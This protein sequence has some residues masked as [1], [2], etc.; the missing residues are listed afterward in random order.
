MQSSYSLAQLIKYGITGV[1]GTM[2]YVALLVVLVELFHI[3]PTLASF[4]SFSS[5][6][7]TSY[8]LNSFWT[9]NTKDVSLVRF[10]KYTIVSLSGLVLTT[11]ITYVGVEVL[12]IWYIYV[13]VIVVLVVPISNYLLNSQWVFSKP[14]SESPPST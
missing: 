7:A 14:A 3:P 5:T 6:V 1:L 2:L 8:F 9:F 11:L 4:L 12:K 13:Q 10:T